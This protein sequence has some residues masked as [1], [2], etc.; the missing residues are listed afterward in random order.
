MTLIECATTSWSS[1]AI[2][3][4][5]STIAAEALPSRLELPIVEAPL[6]DRSTGDPGGTKSSARRRR[7]RQ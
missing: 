4:R 1:R 2:R 7:S 3:A 5:S 6:T